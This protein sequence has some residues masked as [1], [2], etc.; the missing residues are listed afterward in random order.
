M[1]AAKGTPAR[2]LLSML[3]KHPHIADA[4]GNMPDA[5]LNKA[6]SSLPGS[7]GTN[8][9]RM[10]RLGCKVHCLGAYQGEWLL[11]KEDDGKKHVLKVCGVS[12]PQ[13]PILNAREEGP[14]PRQPRSQIDLQQKPGL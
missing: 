1:S 11:H 14:Q 9:I 10:Q 12:D 3:C 7:V 5:I 2:S 6:A 13:Q 8:N 4:Q